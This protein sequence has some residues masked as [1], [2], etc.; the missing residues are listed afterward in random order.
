MRRTCSRGAPGGWDALAGGTP[1]PPR[2]RRP[3]RRRPRGN[4]PSCPPRR[5]SGPRGRNSRRAPSAPGP[6]PP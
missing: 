1:H 2:P 6:T 4:R 3:N 5:H